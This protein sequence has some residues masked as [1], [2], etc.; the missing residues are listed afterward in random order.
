[1]VFVIAKLN[2]KDIYDGCLSYLKDEITDEIPEGHNWVTSSIKNL[3]GTRTPINEHVEPFSSPPSYFKIYFGNFHIKPISYSLMG[4]RTQYK[5]NYLQSWDFYG[6]NQDNEWILLNSH[7]HET[8]SFE[9]ERCFSLEGSDF[10]NGF[11]L[12]MTEPDSDG[13][14]ALCIG[15][16][17]VH[18]YIYKFLPSFHHKTSLICNRELLK[19]ILHSIFV[20][21]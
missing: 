12:K 2:N 14:W 13:K 16:I 15:Q 9:E 8:F 5:S 17:E 21:I 3:I 19:I 18:G 1:M 11:M 10:Y 6:R 7:Y 20:L 4:R